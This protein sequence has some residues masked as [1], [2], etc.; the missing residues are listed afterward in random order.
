MREWYTILVGRFVYRPP[1]GVALGAEQYE[2]VFNG[3]TVQLSERAV[4]IYDWDEWQRY[5]N[6]CIE[7]P[8][9]PGPAPPDPRP[10]PSRKCPPPPECPECL[11]TLSADWQQ[12]KIPKH[13]DDI[14]RTVFDLLG[15]SD[16][17]ESSQQLVNQFAKLLIN[18]PIGLIYTEK[19]QSEV[20][21]SLAKYSPEKYPARPGSGKLI[22]VLNA[23]DL[24]WRIPS[25][26]DKNI[27]ADKYVTADFQ[28]VAWVAF[29]NVNRPG[30]VTLQ[31][32]GDLPASVRGFRSGWPVVSYVFDFTGGGI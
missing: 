10:Y 32:K 3:D 23:L 4:E 19:L 2:A 21:M 1:R 15:P 28:G 25:L 5:I 8:V 20:L 30:K 14:F 31:V 16:D 11:P 26:K 12:W 13:L 6:I 9:I 7:L 17:F 22:E 27:V 18:A 24:D 29:R